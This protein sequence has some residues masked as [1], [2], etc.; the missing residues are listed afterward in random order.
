MIP[1]NKIEAV[2]NAL[3]STFG[4]TETDDI[5]RLN[6]GLSSALVF[7]I[8]VNG[9]PYLLKIITRTDAMTDPTNHFA[10]MKV[11][12]EAGVAPKVWY[13]S[14]EDRF[15]ITDFVEPKPF[16]LDQARVKMPGL[17][18]KLHTLP[19]FPTSAVVNVF[20]MPGTFIPKFKALNIMP[21]A[22]TREI[23][24][25]FEQ[26]YRVYP[27]DKEV[28]VGCHNDLKP[29]N[30][31]F[32]GEQPWLV[33]W[34]AAFLNHRYMDLS[35]VTNFVAKN[36]EEENDFLKRYLGKDPTE[37]E[38][39]CYYL[40]QQVLHLNYFTVFLVLLFSGGKSFDLNNRSVLDYR[41][42]HNRMWAGEITLVE[43]EPRLH[44]GLLHM[45]ELQKNIRS[46][47][48]KGALDLVSKSQ[49]A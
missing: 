17:L 47:R 37:Y 14:I 4:T 2:K 39:A 48:F 23:F 5:R 9:N 40:V 46:Q 42:F 18:R 41:E 6:A 12:A 10:C 28:L 32:D 25:Q 45:E 7:C 8:T 31:I 34:E 44:Y 38:E 33:D 21:E 43:D 30:I 15:S 26:I 13:T 27:R 16:S 22:D 35:I 36:R 20:G 3:K 29:E 49:F 19:G 11:A 24:E 1:E